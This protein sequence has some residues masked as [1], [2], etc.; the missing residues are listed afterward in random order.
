MSGRHGRGYG[1]ET[2]SAWAEGILPA[3]GHPARVRGPRQMDP[4]PLASAATQA[5]EARPQ[6]LWPSCVNSPQQ[7]TP[8]RESPRTPAGGATTRP[9]SCSSVSILATT[10]A[11][12]YPGL[13]A[14][15]ST[16]RT[17]GC[18]PAC[19][20]VWQGCSA[21]SLPPMPVFR[22]TKRVHLTGRSH[23][24][25]HGVRD[26]FAKA[27]S[28]VCCGS[29]GGQPDQA[30]AHQPRLNCWVLAMH[31]DSHPWYEMAPGFAPDQ[32]SVFARNEIAIAALPEH[33]WRW[34]IR[35]ARWRTGTR[36]VRTSPSFPQILRTLPRVFGFHGRH[37][38]R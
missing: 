11:W 4:S 38:A 10:T 27:G 15:T 18:G 30:L 3:G 17:A 12:G 19:P 24:G 20:V 32:S 1:T 5:V 8:Q 25:H 29:G 6:G 23:S 36:T 28:Q 21:T 22:A 31:S 13:P 33:V 16:F 34:P 7:R 35:A 26:P 9:C 14:N 2:I 37:S